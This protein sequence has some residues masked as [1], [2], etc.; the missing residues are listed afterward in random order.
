MS[1]LCT[2]EAFIT[3]VRGWPLVK[4]QLLILA[5]Q[6]QMSPAHTTPDQHFPLVLVLTQRRFK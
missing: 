6:G 5:E 2:L 1:D 3:T 4:V